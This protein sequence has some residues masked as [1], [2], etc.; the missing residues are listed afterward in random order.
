M[1]DKM[2]EAMAAKVAVASERR[3]PGRPANPNTS[4]K[5]LEQH[6]LAVAKYRHGIFGRRANA[7]MS[8]TILLKSRGVEHPV[9]GCHF[10]IEGE[11]GNFR[12]VVIGG[13]DVAPRPSRLLLTGKA[14]A[15]RRM[16][17]AD[18]RLAR[19]GVPRTFRYAILKSATKVLQVIGLENP[20]LDRDF[21]VMKTPEGWVWDF[22]WNDKSS[23]SQVASTPIPPPAPPAPA[24]IETPP[25]NPPD[26][27]ITKDIRQPTILDNRR[28]R[29]KVEEVYDED[30]QRYRYEWSDQTVATNLQVPRAW[31]SRVREL[32]GP[33]VNDSERLRDEARKEASRAKVTQALK[34]AEQAI[35]ISNT[36]IE[37]AAKL[38][39]TMAELRAHQAGL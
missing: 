26:V 7:V 4:Q 39:T 18:K 17:K 35:E 31:V 22:I 33:D 37:L 27:E 20:V 16:E 11:P 6:R 38:E 29:E 2:R 19:P 24:A 28:I 15:L 25:M 32:Y 30:A 8:A 9:E 34:V 5:R 36:I 23:A 12:Y 1:A 13:K 10:K 3:G 21:T 14:V